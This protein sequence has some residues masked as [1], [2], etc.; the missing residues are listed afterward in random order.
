MCPIV[1]VHRRFSSVFPI[2]CIDSEE[3]FPARHAKRGQRKT[4]LLKREIIQRST[5]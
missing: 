5:D 2:T 4:S 3:I 1:P